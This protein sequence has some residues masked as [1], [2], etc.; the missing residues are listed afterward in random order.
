MGRVIAYIIGAALIV[1]GVIAL[2][3]AVEVVRGGGNAEA[4]A[5]GLLVPASLFVV[6]GFVIWM[7]R[8]RND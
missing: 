2:F 1:V 6:G 4:I 5:Q 7:G 8:G 3:G